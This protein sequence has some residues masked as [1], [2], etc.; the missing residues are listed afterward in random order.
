MLTRLT[1]KAPA[2]NFVKYRTYPNL[3]YLFTCD[4]SDFVSY[5]TKSL[6]VNFELQTDF[7]DIDPAL[8]KD[9]EEY[10]TA[11]EFIQNLFVVNDV[12]ERGDKFMKD[13]NRILT[14]DEEEAQF[15]LQ[16]VDSYRK[17]YP[18]HTKPSVN[19]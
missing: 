9:N 4:L 17:K 19:E 2:V 7:S 12:A 1:A 11:S 10:Q 15:I 13:Y 3:Q 8:W 6:F 14:L 18:S 5:K 16:V